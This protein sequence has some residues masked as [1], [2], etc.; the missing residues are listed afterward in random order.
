MS[1]LEVEFF[2]WAG[3]M[4]VV[5]G[6]CS[7]RIIKE[8]SRAAWAMEF[9]RDGDFVKVMT[10]LEDS[11]NGSSISLSFLVVLLFP[12]EGVGHA[13]FRSLSIRIAGFF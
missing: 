4:V 13:V 10:R 1:A 8:L 7:R 2:Q 6:S 12:R 5:D 3:G 11:I 9:Y